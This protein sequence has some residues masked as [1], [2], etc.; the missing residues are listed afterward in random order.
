MT[1]YEPL[2]SGV[3]VHGRTIL[4]VADRALSKF[5]EEYRGLALDA[6][7][8][9]G[10]ENP[11]P[12]EWY[13]QSA[14]LGAFET[15]AT[16]LEPHVLDRLGEQIPAVAEWPTGVQSVHGELA[17]IDDAYQRNHRG[18]EIGEYRHERVDDREARMV[19][20]NPYP[21]EFDR[22]LVR[23]VAR[24][25]AP[26]GSFVLVEERERQAGCRRQDE[27]TCVYTVTW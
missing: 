24:N 4:A 9:R 17:A 10:V 27:D 20:R 22:G 25:S 18:G 26:V 23:A 12:D 13:P 7:A 21:C 15:V 8:R 19:C 1:Q 6:L 5:S 2:D 16:E 11:K 3:E 14:W